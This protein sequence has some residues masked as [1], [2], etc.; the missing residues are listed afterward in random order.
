MMLSI[1]A[2]VQYVNGRRWFDLIISGIAAGAACLTKAPGFLLIPIISSIALLLSFLIHRRRSDPWRRN[3]RDSLIMLSCWGLVG[4]V[5]FVIAWPAMWVSPVGTLSRMFSAVFNYTITG[6]DSPIFFNGQIFQQGQQI[7]PLANFYPITYLWRS[8]PVVLAGLVLAA[9]GLITGKLNTNFRSH[10]TLLSLIIAVVLIF[11]FFSDSNKKFDRYLLPA[12]GPLALIS[13]M[14]WGFLAAWLQKQRPDNMR[15]RLELVLI[16]LIL[17]IQTGF[18]VQ[19]YPYFLSFYNPLL[20]G[21][22]EAPKVMMI[23]WG[24]GLDAAAAYLNEKP[25]AA[26]L[27]VASWYRPSFAYFFNGQAID[28]PAAPN[29][30]QRAKILDS[31]YIVIYISQWQR[32]LPPKL[33]AKLNEKIP[34]YIFLHHGLE[35]ARIYKPPFT[36]QGTS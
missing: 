28:I 21:S 16:F 13:A 11:F 23:G 26:A 27:R 36:S 25:D 8:T 20:G 30:E 10:S 17:L 9:I 12:Y 3:L 15:L 7:S 2:F 34:E 29:P 18:M 33:L 1:L 6:H 35:Y 14:G 5:T 32:D 22:S 19:S 31:D 24:E 4:L